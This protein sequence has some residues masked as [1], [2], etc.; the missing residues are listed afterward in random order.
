MSIAQLHC[1]GRGH[2]ARFCEDFDQALTDAL[3][4]SPDPGQA[5][6]ELDD[7]ALLT[8]LANFAGVGPYD[9]SSAVVGH[10]SPTLDTDLADPALR[11]F[12]W[13]WWWAGTASWAVRLHRTCTHTSPDR[14]VPNPIR[15]GSPSGSGSVARALSDAASMSSASDLSTFCTALRVHTPPARCTGP[16]RSIGLGPT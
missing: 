4:I 7:V 6:T 9:P 12:R 14:G 13:H 5:T 16:G 15:T 10:P 2:E 11:I 8:V 1:I 3:H